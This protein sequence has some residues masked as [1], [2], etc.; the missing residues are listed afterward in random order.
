MPTISATRD[1]T[2]DL[3]DTL[4]GKFVYDSVSEGAVAANGGNTEGI[5]PEEP[6][7]AFIRFSWSGARTPD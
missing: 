6:T 2:W 7:E 3:D 1:K 4:L 5:N